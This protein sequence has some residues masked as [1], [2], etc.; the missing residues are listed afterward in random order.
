MRVK[1]MSV[2]VGHK[3]DAQAILDKYPKLKDF[4]YDIVTIPRK[5]FDNPNKVH[6]ELYMEIDTLAE[7]KMIIDCTEDECGE[8]KEVIIDMYNDLNEFAPTLKIYDGYYE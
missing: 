5:K 3:D 8:F 7:I 2:K 1:I 6:T 4:K